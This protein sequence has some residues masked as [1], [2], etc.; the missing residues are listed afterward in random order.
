MGQ[1]GAETSLS[2]THLTHSIDQD[3]SGTTHVGK[4][5]TYL[6]MARYYRIDLGLVRK[7]RIHLGLVRKYQ[8][9]LGMATQST[10][11]CLHTW[12]TTSTCSKCHAGPS[13]LQGREQG[14]VRKYEAAESTHLAAA[15]RQQFGG[16]QRQKLRS[17]MRLQGPVPLCLLV[18]KRRVSGMPLP[19]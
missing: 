6:G 3:T 9:H 2:V 18:R 14:C 8:I 7:Y 1:E 11:D 13:P 15:S 17:S 12:F 5:R 19:K 10:S 4:Y 16:A